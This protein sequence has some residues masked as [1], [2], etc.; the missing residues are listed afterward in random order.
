MGIVEVGAAVGWANCGEVINKPG[1][2]FISSPLHK[3]VGAP[4]GPMISPMISA[5]IVPKTAELVDRLEGPRSSVEQTIGGDIFHP[6]IS[7]TKE[8]LT[9][10]DRFT[11][12]TTAQPQISAEKRMMAYKPRRFAMAPARYRSSPE[13]S[14]SAH[15]VQPESSG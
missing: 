6:L 2:A 9:M 13:L 14:C 8:G 3:L 11:K 10:W 15:H 5:V 7:F 1:V 12:T 4:E